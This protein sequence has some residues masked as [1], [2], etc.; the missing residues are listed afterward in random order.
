[1]QYRFC[2]KGSNQCDWAEDS[3]ESV[4]MLREK[5]REREN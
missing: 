1:M 3:K 2:T 5:K 4:K